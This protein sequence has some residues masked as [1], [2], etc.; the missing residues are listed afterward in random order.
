MCRFVPDEGLVGLLTHFRGSRCP[1]M[2]T[3]TEFLYIAGCLEL[4]L[5]KMGSGS[6][7]SWLSRIGSCRSIIW[8][9]VH[10]RMCKTIPDEIMFVPLA[11]AGAPTLAFACGLPPHSYTLQNVWIRRWW[12][13]AHSFGPH[14]KIISISIHLMISEFFFDGVILEPSIL[15]VS[16]SWPSE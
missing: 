8:I 11:R 3:S 7:P 1:D 2:S 14:W 5:L 4:N 16:G 10:K 15:A 13:Y 6:L 9:T 12:R